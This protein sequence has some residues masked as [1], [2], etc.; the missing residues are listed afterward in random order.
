MIK[1]CV[2]VD[3]VATV[4]QAR[5]ALEPDPLEAAILA[6]KGG[7]AGI[8]IHL[9][10]DRRHVN[11]SDLHRIRK[12]IKAKLNLE[13]A[14][15]AEIIKIAL[16]ELPDQVTLVPEKRQELTTEGG[17]DVAA[18][19]NRL[20]GIIEEFKRVKIPVSLFIDPIK[21]Q[22]EAAG[23]TGAESI[24]INTAAYS[25]AT[26]PEEEKREA[27]KIKEAATLANSNG[28]KVYAG[29][30]L[31][32]KNT[33]MIATIPHIEELNIG[34]SIV[35]RALMAGMETAVGEMLDI[36]NGKSI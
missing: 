10:E 3:H 33:A 12:S 28:L 26:S 24:E 9:R 7:A 4:R 16:K 2:N 34:H 31:N 17:L 32:Y 18:D 25:E 8:T 20:R 30:G 21:E 13:M 23:R 29:H 27:I 11:D 19:E 5:L 36:L 14:A 22:I 35:A 1:L 15:T 6:L